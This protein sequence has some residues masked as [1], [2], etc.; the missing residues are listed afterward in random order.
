MLQIID[1]E[2]WPLTRDCTIYVLSIGVLTVITYDEKIEWYE[3]LV[4]LLMYMLYFLVMW[5]NG[6][7]LKLVNKLVVRVF[8]TTTAW[9]E[10]GN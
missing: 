5:A 1:L 9:S 8:G 4:L 10:T 3:S 2:W 6:F 7:L